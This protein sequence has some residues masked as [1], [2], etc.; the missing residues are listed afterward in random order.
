MVL[1]ADKIKDEIL[2]Q[3][4]HADGVTFK[5]K[6]D[7]R[8]TKPRK[9]IRSSPS[10]SSLSSSTS[11]KARCL[12]SAPAP[13]P[14]RG[15]P[16]RCAS[17]SPPQSKWITCLWQIGGRADIDFEGQVRLDLEYIHSQSFWKDILI[18]LKTIPAVLLG[19]G[20][21]FESL[22]DIPEIEQINKAGPKY[23]GLRS[24]T[25]GTSI[26]SAK[27]ECPLPCGQ[28]ASRHSSS[29]GSTLR[30]I[31]APKR[32][33]FSWPTA[34]LAVRKQVKERITLAHQV[35]VQHRPPDRP[36]RGRRLR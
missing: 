32:S 7:P 2:T 33:S 21:Y 4:Q 3:N 18:L 15:R 30:S 6:D 14:A 20:A 35:E 24:L 19:K 36:I 26:R 9:W 25:G 34:L 11:S 22:P 5:M 12:W 31:K 10:M 17:S 23:G 1:N 8:I 29:T 16:L 28:S 27:R 13:S